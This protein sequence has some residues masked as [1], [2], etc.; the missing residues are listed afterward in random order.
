MYLAKADASALYVNLYSP[1][2][3]TWSERES[4]SRNHPLPRGAGQHAHHRGGPA[5]FA[6]LLR[7]PAWATG[8]FRVTVN[9]RAVPGTP[10]PVGYFSV[11]RTWQAGD[12]VRV[13]VPFRLRAE[14]A[15]DDPTLQPLFPGPVNLVARAPSTEHLQCALYGNVGLSG[16]LLPSLTPVAGKRLHHT[17]NGVGFAPFPEGGREPDARPL[18]ALGPPCGLRRRR[19]R[20]RPGRRRHAAGRDL[21]GALFG[22]KG[23]LVTRVRTTVADRALAGLPSG[24]DGDRVARTA[25]NASSAA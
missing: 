10:V 16:D 2:E 24:T 19:R 5:S 8:G 3:L 13:L 7:V 23:A 17:L 11:R 12:T 1:S 4:R 21:G 20:P 18:P 6:L 25:Q 22:S 14:R 9:G 15:L